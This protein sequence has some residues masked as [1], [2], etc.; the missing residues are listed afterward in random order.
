MTAASAIQAILV[1]QIDVNDVEVKVLQWHVER[2]DS[3]VDGDLVCVVETAKATH[4]IHSG[5][6]GCVVPIV[7][8]GETLK[9]GEVL[10]YV[11]P[12]IA[13]VEAFIAA[14]S[15]NDGADV[16]APPR[17]TTARATPRAKELAA[18]HGID[19]AAVPHL[20]SLIKEKDVESFLVASPGNQDAAASPSARA[21]G[22]A[23]LPDSVAARVSMREQPRHQK[24]IRRHLEATRHR[25]IAASLDMEA[26]VDEAET[27]LR[28][29]DL[30][31]AGLF[32]LILALV[33]RHLPQFPL[34]KSFRHGDEICE[35]TTTDVAFTLVD[36]DRGHRLLTPV[37]RSPASLPLQSL[38]EAC[39]ELSL[40]AYRGEIAQEDLEGGCFTLTML[41]GL[42]VSRFV[43]LPNQWQ[44]AILAIGSPVER[45]TLSAGG[46]PERS[47]TV[48]LTLT[49]DH[50]LCDGFYAGT[51]LSR[52]REGLARG[53][54]P[55]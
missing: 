38:A 26:P 1:P 46:K 42:P 8:A 23:S 13:A 47:R 43:G 29:S 12:D 11:G 25:V 18:F 14:R 36:V 17:E 32:H 34:L 5:L 27:L 9:V 50:G 49:Y 45:L 28:E 53:E 37:V 2:G 7:L 6:P 24:V 55:A 16:Q 54:V 35:Y 33:A 3:V 10:A 52:V 41:T 15:A 20:G 31:P 44:S 21:P 30:A 19:L 39:M 48:A 51:F 4:E 22:E 40:R